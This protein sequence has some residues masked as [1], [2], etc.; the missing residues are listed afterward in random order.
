MNESGVG[1]DYNSFKNS[2]V[3]IEETHDEEVLI[4]VRKTAVVARSKKK[5]VLK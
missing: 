5:K 3:G 1:I 4:K 2:M